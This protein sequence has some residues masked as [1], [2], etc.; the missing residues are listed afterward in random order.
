MVHS[1][2]R[3]LRLA[4]LAAGTGLIAGCTGEP[5][6]SGGSETTSIGSRRARGRAEE[7]TV[8]K[9]FDGEY[10][11]L[12]SENAVRN[13]ESNDVEPFDRWVW[14]QLRSISADSV[15]S[16]LS[17]R[18]VGDPAVGYPLG[19][20]TLAITVSLTTTL[21]RDGN[22]EFTPQTSFEDV[23]AVTPRSVTVTVSLDGKTRT[24]TVPVWVGRAV[25]QLE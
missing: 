20:E 24:E 14:A 25:E 8:S 23:A 22:V 21:D 19:P 4:S 16:A 6:G 18:G 12:A 5:L 3:V 15:E 10:T 11:Y 9:A 1:R 7:I 13:E 17:S 2:R